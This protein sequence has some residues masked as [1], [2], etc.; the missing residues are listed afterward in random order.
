MSETTETKV[1]ERQAWPRP[2]YKPD[3][4]TPIVRFMIFGAFGKERPVLDATRHHVSGPPEGIEAY[5]VKAEVARRMLEPNFMKE[6]WGDTPAWEHAHKAV[7][8]V[9]I[10]GSP[11]DDSTLDYLR[12]TIGLVTAFLEKAGRF[13]AILDM[14]SLILRDAK[15]W[16]EDVHRPQQPGPAA[17]VQTFSVLGGEKIKLQSRGLL[18]F[19]RP[20]IEIPDVTEEWKD[21]AA[22]ALSHAITAQVQGFVIEPGRPVELKGLPPGTV[23]ELHDATNVPIYPNRF[24]R[25]VSKAA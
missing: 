4:G 17:F 21:P 22:R 8:A 24:F 25:F 19:G 14:N 7:N 11:K 20:D 13:P 6:R 15:T 9:Q 12:K 10:H 5:S 2:F 3:A 18:T 16:I 23:A 1:P